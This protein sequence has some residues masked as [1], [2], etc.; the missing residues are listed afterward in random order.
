VHSSFV[1]RK[2]ID[3]TR[4]PLTYLVKRVQRRGGRG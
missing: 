1:L 2:P 3:T 4:L